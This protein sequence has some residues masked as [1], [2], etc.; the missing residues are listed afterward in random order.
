MKEM[1]KTYGPKQLF[2]PSSPVIRFIPQSFVGVVV[3]VT[4]KN[5]KG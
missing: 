5:I 1:I 3:Y 4:I 2:G